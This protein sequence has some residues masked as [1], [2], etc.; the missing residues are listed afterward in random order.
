MATVIADDISAPGTHALVIGVSAY[1]HLTGGAQ[2][3]Q[4]GIDTG[5]EQL[6][7]AARSASD[8]AQWLQT[9]PYRSPLPPLRSLRVLLSP[10]ADEQI[11]EAYRGLDQL[12]ATRAQVEAALAGFWRACCS[13]RDNHAVVYVAGH[14]IQLSKTGALLLLEDFASPD[15]LQLLSGAL[16][17]AGIH[18]AFNSDGAPRHQFWFVD[19]CRQIPAVARQFEN[20]LSGA[21]SLDIKNA[22]SAESSML[23]LSAITGTSAYG[24]PGGRSLFA[25]A[26]LQTLHDGAAAEGPDGQALEHWHVPV[27]RLLATLPR[28]VS[29]AARLLEREQSVEAAGMPLPAVFHVYPETPR[30]EFTVSLQPDAAAASSQ[31]IV[32][33]EALEPVPTSA[34]WPSTAVVDAGLYQVEVQTAAPYRPYKKLVNVK[35]PMTPHTARVTP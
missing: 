1:R 22:G 5:M 10:G 3:T 25:E 29:E 12:A 20:L 34:E 7:S 14:G 23:L 17:L 16:D 19:A 24:L 32:R 30:A 26:L 6:R 35:P 4:A 31:L 27:T 33:D 15:R 21:L 28:R 8:V 13:H 11:A 9:R 18:R 2:P